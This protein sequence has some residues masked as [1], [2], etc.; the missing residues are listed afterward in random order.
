MHTGRAS[1]ALLQSFRE[2]L[3]DIQMLDT[4]TGESDGE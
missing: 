2:M 3:S 4:E 1:I